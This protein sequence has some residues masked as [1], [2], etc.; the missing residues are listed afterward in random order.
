MIVAAEGAVNETIRLE[1]VKM[2]MAL[3]DLKADEVEVY[4]LK[5]E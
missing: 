1:I 3:Y 2:V 5:R 4:P